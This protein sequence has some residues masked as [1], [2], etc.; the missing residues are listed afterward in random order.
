MENKQDQE[1]EKDIYNDNIFDIQSKE[2]L[3]ELAKIQLLA[4]DGNKLKFRVGHDFFSYEKDNDRMLQYPDYKSL[5]EGVN[6]KRIYEKGVEFDNDYGQII[7]QGLDQLDLDQYKEF[8][9]EKK[10][11]FFVNQEKGI[12]VNF[13]L[14]RGQK[15]EKG[16]KGFSDKLI[17]NS[18]DLKPIKEIFDL[19]SKLASFLFMAGMKRSENKEGVENNK[20]IGLVIDEL[21]S[22]R[23]ELD[24]LQNDK[25][26]MDKVPGLE[27]VL[28]EY[29]NKYSKDLELN[30]DIDKQG[31]VVESEKNKQ[32]L[33]NSLKELEQLLENKFGKPNPMS[34]D[35]E[36]N[37]SELN[38][39]I[40]ENNDTM[41]YLKDF[42]K[43]DNSLN[44]QNYSAHEIAAS[45]ILA[46]IKTDLKRGSFDPKDK[47][48]NEFKKFVMT[49]KLDIGKIGNFS[50]SIIKKASNFAADQTQEQTNQN[51][52]KL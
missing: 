45:T 39:L 49:N 30:L 17:G 35:G 51:P 2:D 9:L 19:F 23:I 28:E 29:K 25:A 34:L 33:D 48:F 7:K 27:G 11:E 24:K 21:N 32:L 26:F 40:P 15:I 20:I 5:Y 46:G 44:Y 14:E 13:N 1:Q 4:N 36:K 42:V 8:D 47:M 41:S 38:K 12:N 16:L 6:N 31:N 10:D 3:K 43:K 37:L 50:N 52:L 18:E 22:D